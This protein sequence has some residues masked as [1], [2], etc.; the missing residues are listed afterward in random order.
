M[1]S[2]YYIQPKNKDETP[3]I[4][5]SCL[6]S[7]ECERTRDN[8]TLTCHTCLLIWNYIQREVTMMLPL[9][10]IMVLLHLQVSHI[11]NIIIKWTL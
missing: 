8:K 9:A 5:Q 4:V 2:P 6:E 11:L 7:C 1:H 10:W 3:S